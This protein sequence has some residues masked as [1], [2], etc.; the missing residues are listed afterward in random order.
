MPFGPDQIAGLKLWLQATAITGLVDGD[1][2]TTWEDSSDQNNDATQAVATAQPTYQSNEVNGL[3]VVRFD[4]AD[5]YLVLPATLDLTG[6][7]TVFVVF[8]AAIISATAVFLYGCNAGSE[9]ADFLAAGTF[10]SRIL[11]SGDNETAASAHSSA[12][13]SATWYVLTLTKTTGNLSAV[14]L[15]GAPDTQPATDFWGGA[16]AGV[17]LGGSWTGG[18][19]LAPFGGDLAE[20]LVYDSVLANGDRAAVEDYLYTKYAIFGMG[21]GAAALP[22]GARPIRLTYEDRLAVHLTSEDRRP[23][24]LSYEDILTITLT[25]QSHAG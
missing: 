13:G 23:L 6:A 20:V 19:L 22:V 16:T 4:G 9:N 5:D 21:G 8:R 17:V 1:P 14:R 15:N 18:S 7:R 3:P 10:N 24:M 11:A 12:L 2:I 25:D